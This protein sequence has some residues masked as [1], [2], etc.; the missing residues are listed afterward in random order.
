M[1]FHGIPLH[2]VLLHSMAFHGIQ[3]HISTFLC[4]AFYH[5]ALHSSSVWHFM[6]FDGIPSH[7]I[8]FLCISL[9]FTALH[10]IPLGSIEFYAASIYSFFFFSSMLLR[11][12]RLLSLAEAI[13]G[14]P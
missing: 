14:M 7:S 3:W 13:T 8:A 10:G 2:C 1:S 4:M 6:A 5:M 11:F 9:H 12:V